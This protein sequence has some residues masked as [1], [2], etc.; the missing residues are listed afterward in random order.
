MASLA[1][2]PRLRVINSFRMRSCKSREGLPARGRFRRQAL[3]DVVEVFPMTVV[4]PQR[5]RS[6]RCL[7]R[8]LRRRHSTP[9]PP[10]TL[11]QVG[12]RGGNTKATWK[13]Q[14]AHKPEGSS[15]NLPKEPTEV[16]AATGSGNSSRSWSAFRGLLPLSRRC[17]HATYENF[18]GHWPMFLF[19]PVCPA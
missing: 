4:A 1:T 13:K 15:L 9:S 10:A 6:C 3:R 11:E 8:L 12:Q 7:L 2:S 17:L 5:K 14:T 19:L 18:N 16:Q